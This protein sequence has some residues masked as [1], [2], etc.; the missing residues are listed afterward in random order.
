MLSNHSWK[1]NILCEKVRTK[2]TT[3][4]FDL[5]HFSYICN[6][7]LGKNILQFI[8]YLIMFLSTVKSPTKICNGSH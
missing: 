6:Y 3:E 4:D 2:Y 8:Y 7:F 1:E 5:G